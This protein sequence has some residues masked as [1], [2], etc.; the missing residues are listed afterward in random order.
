MKIIGQVLQ[1]ARSTSLCLAVLSL[2]SFSLSLPAATGQISPRAGEKVRVTAPALGLEEAIGV[3]R[4]A[5]V[6]TLLID[7]D[8]TGA[9]VLVRAREVERMEVALN[10]GS[11]VGVGAVFGFLVGAGIGAAIGRARGDTNCPNVFRGDEIC[12][13]WSQ[14]SKTVVGA[15]LGG[16]A[17]AG[18]GTLI[19]KSFKKD[20]WRPAVVG[21]AS[22][23][24]SPGIGP[25]AT[26]LVLGILF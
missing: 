10:Q 21:G 1:I 6:G 23:S 25:G 4:E 15:L 13:A 17:G 19:G 8:Q 9:D 7:L 5:G 14:D 3:V 18:I 20:I 2:G 12:L 24:V 26:G 22:V 11:Y 16:V